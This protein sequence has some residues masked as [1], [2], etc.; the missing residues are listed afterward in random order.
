MFETAV[1]VFLG[2]LFFGMSIVDKAD[3]MCSF[4]DLFSGRAFSMRH[5]AEHT[6][7]EFNG[8]VICLTLAVGAFLIIMVISAIGQAQIGEPKRVFLKD[9]ENDTAPTHKT[10][11]HN[12]SQHTKSSSASASGTHHQAHTTN[13][14]HHYPAQ[15]SAQT[16]HLT[17]QTVTTRG[18][19]V[20]H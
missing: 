4:G 11:Q 9:L 8:F 7:R 10:N 2:I 18:A 5:Q 19:G 3:D 14:R 6:N 16:R 1:V 12:G 15:H 17:T 13:N 20:H